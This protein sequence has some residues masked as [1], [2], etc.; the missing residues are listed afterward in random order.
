MKRMILGFAAFLMAATPVVAQDAPLVSELQTLVPGET[1]TVV[2]AYEIASDG[3]AR[4][5]VVE[6]SSGFA[7]LDA[8]SCEMMLRFGRFPSGAPARATRTIRWVTP[9][10]RA[11]AP[12]PVEQAERPRMSAG[13]ADEWAALNPGWTTDPED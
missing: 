8:A 13:S 4:D 12:L 3:R 1:G 2:L 10:A 5:C 11:A 6:R 9:T 7:R